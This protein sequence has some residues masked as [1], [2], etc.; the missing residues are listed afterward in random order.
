MKDLRLQ[1]S[2]NQT[3]AEDKGKFFH[4]TTILNSKFQAP[5]HKQAGNYKFQ[6]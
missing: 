5:N 2:C 3:A 1:G 6:K 4:G